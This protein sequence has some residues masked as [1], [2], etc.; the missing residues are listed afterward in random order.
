[1]YGQRL[2]G[3]NGLVWAAKEADE[4]V[5]IYWGGLSFYAYHE[6]DAF[7]RK[8]GIALLANQGVHHQTICELFAVNRHTVRKT[9]AVYTNSTQELLGSKTTIEV[10]RQLKKLCVPL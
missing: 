8:L 10:L 6:N 2:L 3:P 1:M 7:E 9:L 4:I 5:R